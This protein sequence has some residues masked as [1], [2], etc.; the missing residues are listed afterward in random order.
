[1]LKLKLVPEVPGPE[2]VFCRQRSEVPLFVPRI[3][4]ESS[5]FHSF[6]RFEGIP[7]GE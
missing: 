6:G 1:M 3:E 4:K 2:V 5:V 7:R